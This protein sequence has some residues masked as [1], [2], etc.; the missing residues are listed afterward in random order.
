[1]VRV[2]SGDVLEMVDAR[3]MDLLNELNSKQR[4]AKLSHVLGGVGAVIGAIMM[5]SLGINGFLMGVVLALAGF[6]AGASID[7]F[8]RSVVVMYDLEDDAADA[9]G[10]LLGAFDEMKKSAG[11]WRIDSGV[12]FRTSPLGKGTLAPATLSIERRRRSITPCPPFS[13]AT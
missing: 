11:I 10:A 9:Y 8:R 12:R 13:N 7:S 5:F 3:F 4:Q 1:M 6:A 2:S